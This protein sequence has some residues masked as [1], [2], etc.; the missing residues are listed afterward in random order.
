MKDDEFNS[1]V[2]CLV[3]SGDPEPF[4]HFLAESDAAGY[5]RKRISARGIT[6]GYV[7]GIATTATGAA[8]NGVMRGEA[9][10]VESVVGG[11]LQAQVGADS[12]RAWDLARLS[13]TDAIRKFLGRCDHF[14]PSVAL[15]RLAGCLAL[16]P[17]LH[18]RNHK[19]LSGKGRHSP[20]CL[21]DPPPANHALDPQGLSLCC[22]IAQRHRPP[23]H[24]DSYFGV[25]VGYERRRS[26]VVRKIAGGLLYFFTLP[27]PLLLPFPVAIRLFVKVVRHVWP[28][29]NVLTSLH[30]QDHGVVTACKQCRSKKVRTASLPPG[31]PIAFRAD[32]SFATPPARS[33]PGSTP[34]RQRL[35]RCRP[36]FSRWMKRAGSPPKLRG[37]PS[38]CDN[39]PKEKS[40]TGH[41]RALSRVRPSRGDPNRES[42]LRLW[43]GLADGPG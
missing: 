28:P 2:V 18:L 23:T 6:R 3:G 19:L 11:T 8:F 35:K 17:R 31:I 40:A 41:G 15:P 26:N 24:G 5:A 37:C 33:S 1:Y 36:R 32:T 34:A 39:K 29:L 27:L 25:V 12:K 7:F 13:G 22:C 16:N 14:R 4:A 42:G 10:L 20:G 43:G 21:H 38:Y 9:E 30:H